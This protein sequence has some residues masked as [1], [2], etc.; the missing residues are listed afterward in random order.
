MTIA[1]L[2]IPIDQE[3]IA[4]FC[5]ERGIRKMSLSVPWSGR[6]SMLVA[7]MWM[8]LWNFCRIASPAGNSSIG[9][10]TWN[11]FLDGR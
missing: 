2:P 10:K 1:E 7:V 9:T 6:I 11:R 5:R 3:K 8:S 4:A